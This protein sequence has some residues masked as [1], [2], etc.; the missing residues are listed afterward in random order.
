MTTADPSF[1]LDCPHD[2]SARPVLTCVQACGRLDGVL[3]EL[4]LRQTYR[5]SGSR[6]LE[7]VYTFPLAQQAVLLGSASELNGERKEGTVV[8]KTTADRQYETAFA[9]GDAPVMLEALEGGLHCA[10][11]GN[12]EPGDELV[13]EVRYAQLLVFEQGRLRLAIPTTIAPR[14]GSAVRAGLQ[15]QQVP[16]ASLLPDYPLTLSVQV[17]GSLSGARIECPTHCVAQTPA[18]GGLR[19][20]LA[21]GARLD[22][23][24]VIVLMPHEAQASFVLEAHDA[25]PGAAPV[26]L[27]A[28]LQMPPAP[29]R[30]Q[31]VLKL[32]LDC[33]GSMAGDSIASARRALRAALDGLTAQDRVSVSRFGSRVEHLLAPGAETHRTLRDLKYAVDTIPA[34]MGGT[35]MDG[36]LRAVFDLDLSAADDGAADHADVLMFTDGEIWQSQEIVARAMAR[37]HRIFVI[38]VGSSPAEGVLRTIAQ[39]TG[40]ACEF[41]TPGEALEAAA[42]RM[43]IRI[44]QSSW[45]NAR[46]DWGSEAAWWTPL[47][48]VFGGDTVVAFAGMPV[49]AG[50]ARTV[51]TVR[52]LVTDAQGTTTL[53]SQAQAKVPGSTLARMAAAQRLAHVAP[54]DVMPMA[55]AYQLMSKQTNCILVHARAEADKAIGQA[56]LHRVSSMLAAG[57]GGSA[58]LM[59]TTLPASRSQVN[60]LEYNDTP[61]EA[62]IPPPLMAARLKAELLASQPPAAA[63]SPDTHP[64]THPTRDRLESL[65]PILRS[66]LAY[67][68]LTGQTQG[69]AAHCS[70]LALEPAVRQALVQVT[71]FGISDDLAWLILAFWI[72]SEIAG[73]H[74]QSN[75]TLLEPH[76]GHLRLVIVGRCVDRFDQLLENSPAAPHVPSRSQRILSAM[77]RTLP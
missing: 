71:T 57:W 33:S 72:S 58:M 40:G 36:A 23:D 35:D 41:A 28:A 69:L 22:R 61:S 18:A 56:Q 26:V 2:S 25:V 46:I 11:I 5:N 30:E 20:T 15:P 60:Y 34:D 9:E 7:V 8:A 14:C 43:L 44:R 21:P 68:A 37:R 66:V 47:P 48:N 24:L 31:I 52:L 63:M 13:I 67:V 4:T 38:G 6:L 10:N 12:L 19:L 75:A 27:M 17:E 74:H 16:V 73:D 29:P 45:R 77:N 54:N 64:G 70:T 49:L 51:P 3:F 62:W 39:A 32:L 55:V 65:S 59:E 1:M 50:G 76:F 42:N 53:L